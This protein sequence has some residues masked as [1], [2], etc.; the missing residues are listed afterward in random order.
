MKENKLDRLIEVGYDF[1]LVEAFRAGWDMFQVKP[2]YSMAYGMLI[3]SCQIMFA[4]YL[5]DIAFVFSL[6][7]A[8]PLY[9]GFFLV[10]NKISRNEE[11][12]Y[13]DFFTGFSYYIPVI[14][15]WVV[16]QVLAVIGL[17]FFIIPGVYLMV[18]YLFGVLMAIFGGMDFW[19]AMEYSRRLIHVKWW[20]FFLLALSLL[21]LNLLG[22]LLFIV[23]LIATL[24][25]TYYVIYCLFEEITREALVEE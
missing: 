23:G 14:L 22:A 3:V 7:L 19:K 5:N 1:D 2:L 12:I 15:V 9:A 8:G 4:V 13:P 20:K 18:G 21:I 25:L 11:V 17:F 10:A 6:F 16:A 24:P